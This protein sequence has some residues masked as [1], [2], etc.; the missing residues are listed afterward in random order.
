MLITLNLTF[1]NDY[2]C[3]NCS[4]LYFYH[5]FIGRNIEYIY[6]EHSCRLKNNLH[7][8][9][10]TVQKQQEF[11]QASRAQISIENAF[12]K[13]FKIDILDN[14]CIIWPKR[15]NRTYCLCHLI[16]RLITSYLVIFVNLKYIFPSFRNL[17]RANYL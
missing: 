16:I 3:S 5:T 2:I 1:F 14:L 9:I 11:F 12:L 10:L 15:Y 4:I 7:L 8:H 6:L 17:N 13:W